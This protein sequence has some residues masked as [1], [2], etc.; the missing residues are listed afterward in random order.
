LTAKA[1]TSRIQ[2]ETG[3]GATIRASDCGPSG[4]EQGRPGFNQGR[5]SFS[6]RLEFQG[7]LEVITIPARYQCNFSFPIVR[8]S[9]IVKI[10][11][12]DLIGRAIPA[13]SDNASD[14][15]Q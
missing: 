10:A 5:Q 13:N 8:F 6:P 2:K 4:V 7:T 9:L 1:D 14:S 12:Q 15:V 3:A 11:V